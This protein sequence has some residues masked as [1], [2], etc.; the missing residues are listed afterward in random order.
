MIQSLVIHIKD[1]LRLGAFVKLE[2]CSQ[3]I[4]IGHLHL[5]DQKQLVHLFCELCVYPVLL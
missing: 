5:G 2:N 4:I 3:I 1:L